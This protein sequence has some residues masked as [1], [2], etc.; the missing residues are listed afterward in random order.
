MAIQ[1]EVSKVLGLRPTQRYTPG[2]CISLQQESVSVRIDAKHGLSADLRE[3]PWQQIL[4]D[5]RLD[6]TKDNGEPVDVEKTVAERGP[7]KLAENVRSSSVKY[8]P[9]K[10]RVWFHA[11]FSSEAA[12]LEDWDTTWLQPCFRVSTVEGK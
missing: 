9:V 12:C 3:A 5:R 4:K 1:G 11:R 2:A 6:L 7:G 8:K 10:K